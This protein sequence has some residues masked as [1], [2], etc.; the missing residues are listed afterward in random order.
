MLISLAAAFQAARPGVP[1]T[2]NKVWPLLPPDTSPSA[3]QV[4]FLFTI[5]MPPKFD[6]TKTADL[7]VVDN[8]LN[9]DT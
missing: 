5:M 9:D 1:P 4:T 8:V 6:I 3:I 7:F 2:Q